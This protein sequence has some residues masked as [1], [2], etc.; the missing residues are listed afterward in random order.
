MNQAEF[1]EKHANCLTFRERFGI[2]S[3]GIIENDA[4]LAYLGTRSILFRAAQLG[5]ASSN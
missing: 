2:M 4:Q 5:Y 3:Q 1:L